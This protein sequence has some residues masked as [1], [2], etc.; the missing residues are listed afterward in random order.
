MQGEIVGINEEDII[1]I[2]YIYADHNIH[3]ENEIDRNS[4]DNSN[5]DNG[6]SNYDD[7]DD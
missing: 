6:N 7:N 1:D 5:D 2:P 4:E 3:N